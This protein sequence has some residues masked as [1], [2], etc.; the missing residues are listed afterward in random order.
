[1]VSRK[2]RNGIK[3][4][5]NCEFSLL[6]SWEEDPLPSC[7]RIQK[8]MAA[9]DWHSWTPLTIR[10]ILVRNLASISCSLSN[11]EINIWH[12]LEISSRG[13]KSLTI[14]SLWTTISN[15]T[16]SNI[17][18][19]PTYSFPVFQARKFIPNLHLNVNI[20]LSMKSGL[21]EEEGLSQEIRSVF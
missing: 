15:N 9:S 14:S 18:W 4:K 13:G 12:L 17:N 16:I 11:L 8:G 19:G 1:M 20:D 7:P 6:K 21:N 10:I 2:L 3:N 5:R